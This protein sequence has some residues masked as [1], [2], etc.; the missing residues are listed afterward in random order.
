MIDGNVLDEIIFKE[1][2]KNFKILIHS[3]NESFTKHTEW[4]E[5]VDHLEVVLPGLPE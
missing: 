1:I 4:Y 3:F 5:L 2:Y